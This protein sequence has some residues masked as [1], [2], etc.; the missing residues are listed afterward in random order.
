[1]PALRKPHRVAFLVPELAVDGGDA[2]NAAEAGLLL[3]IACIEVCQR[4]PGLAVFDAES[5]PLVS[6]DGHFTPDHARPGATPGDSFYGP[7]RRDELVWLELALPRPGPVRLHALARDGQHDTFEVAGRNT[8]DQIHQALERWLAARGLGALPR[9]FEAAEAGDLLAA[10]RVFAAVLGEQ[11]RAHLQGDPPSGAELAGAGADRSELGGDSGPGPESGVAEVPV[12]FPGRRTTRALA[13]RLTAT[14]R[15]PALRLVALALGED[16]GDAILDA[17]PDQPQALFARFRAELPRRRDDALLRRI[18][19]GAPGWA[20]PYR[21]L[22]D[23]GSADPAGADAERAGDRSPPTWLETS[24]GAG[25]AAL[26][27]PGQLDVI[28]TAAARLAEDGR[29]D[30]GLRVLERAVALY[31]DSA[32]AHVALLRLH[33]RAGRL[34]AWLAQA[35]ASAARHG[36]PLDPGLPMYG[37]QIQ[38]DLLLADALLH[39]G[40]IAEAIALRASR[41][42][43]RAASWPRHTR[44]LAT[45]RGEPQLLARSYAREGWLRGDPGRALEGYGRT[46]PDE[47]VDIAFLLDALVATGREAEV[48]LAWSQFGLGRELTEPVARLAAARCLLAAGEWRRGSEELWRVSLTEPGRDIQAQ[49]A[50]AGLLL[51]CASIDALEAALGERLAIGALT[52]ARRMARDVADFVP[53]AARSSIVL[54]ALGRSAAVEFDPAWL[55][56]FPA[57]TRSRRAID[58]LF[59]EPAPPRGSSPAIAAPP[60]G[61]SPAIAPPPGDPAELLARRDRLVH[62]WLPVVFTEVG[63]DDAAGLAQAAAY[64]AGCALGRYLAATTAAPSPLTGGYRVIAAEALAL[65]WRHRGALADRDARALLGVLEP[66]L[67]RIDRWLGSLWLGVIERSCAIDERANGDVAG[68]AREHPT[69]AARILGPEE[70]AVLGASV[71]RLYRERPEGWASAVAAQ[72]S[73][74]ASHTGHAGTD[75]WADAVVAQLAAREIET[76]DAIDVLHTACYLA[77]DRTAAPCTHAARVLLAAGRAPAAVSVLCA[78]LGA[79]TAE[80]R[81]AQVAA[82]AGPWA[83]AQVDLPLDRER[84]TAQLFEALEAGEPVRAE[85]LG[86]LAVALDPDSAEA[87]RNLGLALAQQGKLPEALHHLTLGEP[88]QA[89]ELLCGVLDQGGRHAEASAVRAYARRWLEPTPAD[90]PEPAAAGDPAAPADPSWRVRRAALAA[91]RLRSPADHDVAVPPRARAAAEVVLADAI[92]AAGHEAVLARD[93]ALA[94]REQAYFARDPLPQLGDPMA[95][96]AFHRELV[97]RGG[98]LGLASGPAS[99]PAPDAPAPAARSADRNAVPDGQLS[100]VSDYVALIRDLS[101]LTPREALAEFDLD[102]AGYLEVATAWARAIAGDPTLAAAI[103]AGLAKR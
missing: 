9:R 88:D 42:E 32:A 58:A 57:D 38:I 64:M 59:A 4:H 2:P 75:E 71:A 45:W 33:R 21:E 54:R 85:K 56:G 55:A 100:R 12:V 92:G 76:E 97:A 1:V 95:R 72:A 24:A 74:L 13:G 39:A 30:D 50:R 10:V 8:G 73:R 77:E 41:L 63:E 3:W 17:D 19:A 51:S 69:V 61:S 25:I 40:R 20:L 98:A 15:A 37:D 93:L 102:D 80:W 36:C 52:L 22:I 62:D 83:D 49:V 43:G 35:Q 44:I 5:T 47:A 96:D 84:A 16:L 94:I 28:Q 81:A 70:T 26:C 23:D 86:R 67:R 6:Q 68:F 7:T 103:A 11:A 18:I 78:G 89:T 53:G 34:G 14:L 60:R 79:G 66:L 31:P 27:Q 46:R 90:A 91:T 87:Q 29:I 82:L 65:V 101:V 99:G 48:A